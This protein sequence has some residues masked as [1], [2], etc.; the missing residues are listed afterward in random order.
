MTQPGAHYWLFVAICGHCR[1]HHEQ[2]SDMA[3]SA[4]SQVGVAADVVRG[5]D[6]GLQLQQSEHE[7][8]AI[9][10]PCVFYFTILYSA[11]LGYAML[12]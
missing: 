7:P 10:L 8:E 4:R 1:S 3:S 11:M 9:I 12:C 5:G 2:R 6:E